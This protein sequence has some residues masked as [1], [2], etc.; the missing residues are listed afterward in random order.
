M[1]AVVVVL[2]DVVVV[3]VV[4]AGSMTVKMASAFSPLSSPVALTM[5]FP[6]GASTG[7]LQVVVNVPSALFT[8]DMR[9]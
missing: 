4:A 3:V 1:A 5:Y 6:G 9:M 2:G 8:F 7:T